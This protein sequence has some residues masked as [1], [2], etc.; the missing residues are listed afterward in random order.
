[1]SGTKQ[2][3]ITI[4]GTTKYGDDHYITVQF[5]KTEEVWRIG[6]LHY[7]AA[8]KLRKHSDFK[9]YHYIKKHG[10]SISKGDR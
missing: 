5:P 9:F 3:N 7:R 2:P 1:M 10:D 8:K 6:T 4:M